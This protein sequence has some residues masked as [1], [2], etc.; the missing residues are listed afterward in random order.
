M[1]F[2]RKHQHRKAER[3][4]DKH[5]NKHTLS[6]V[7]IVGGNRAKLLWRYKNRGRWEVCDTYL[8][9]TGPGVSPRMMAAAAMAPVNCAMQ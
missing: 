4:G 1:L 6:E 3:R 5:L 9:E 2:G 8:Y 7:D